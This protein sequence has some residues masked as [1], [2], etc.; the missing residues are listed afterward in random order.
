MIKTVII[1]IASLHTFIVEEPKN[2]NAWTEHIQKTAMSEYSTQKTLWDGTRPDLLGPM[3][4]EVDWTYKWKEGVGQACY[5]SAVTGKPACLLLLAKDLKNNKVDVYKAALA[6]KHAKVKL[7][8]YDCRK[9]K[10]VKD[11]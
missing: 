3:A 6:C 11:N 5:Y 1:L 10:F 7:I 2:E 9:K 8:L 4:V